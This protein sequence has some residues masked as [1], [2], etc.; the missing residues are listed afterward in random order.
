MI[1]E[2][3]TRSA[4]A[5]GELVSGDTIVVRRGPRV[6]WV[7]V[8]DVLG[9]G[10]LA[11]AVAAQARGVLEVS[12]AIDPCALMAD[13]HAGLRGTRGAAAAICVV[14]GDDLLG[15]SVGNIETRLASGACAAIARPGIVGV[16]L[17]AL[18]ATRVRIERRDRLALWSDGISSRASLSS[19]RALSAADACAHLI[20]DHRRDHDDASVLV[21]DLERV[22]PPSPTRSPA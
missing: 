13:L 19:C 3:A 12:R 18:A 2:L 10:S 6:A 15:C 21:A 22:A 16:R 11:A 14:D 7:A 17:P 20:T 8:I 9:H 4:P 5:A 1:V